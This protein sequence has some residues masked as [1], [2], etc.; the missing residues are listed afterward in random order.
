MGIIEI[1]LI[2]LGLSMDA[3]AVSMTDGMC[4]RELGRSKT[5]L[6]P[7]S[8]GFFQALMPL[9]GYYA[10]SLFSEFL[11]AYAGIVVLL[12]LG[13]IGG[14]MIYDGLR[15]E[16]ERA[17]R[18][19]PGLTIFLQAIATSIDAFA[20]GVGFNAMRVQILPTVLLIGATT[21]VCSL[22]AVFVGK[23][24]GNWLGDKAQILGGVILILI[25]IKSLF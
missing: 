12:I 25:G 22:A 14:K 6:I 3:V 9:L 1:L 5:F 13:V 10:G 2:G 16:E 15:K 17:C 11:D 20:V 18:R 23:R 24:F 19:L 8:F 4:G 7:A 21:F